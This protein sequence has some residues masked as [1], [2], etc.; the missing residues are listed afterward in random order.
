MAIITRKK[1]SA[2]K[3]RA[4]FSQRTWSLGFLG[5]AVAIYIFYT[6]IVPHTSDGFQNQ[7]QT[8]FPPSSLNEALV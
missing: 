2:K 7:I 3:Q 8:W 4:P 5:L 1:K 6:Y